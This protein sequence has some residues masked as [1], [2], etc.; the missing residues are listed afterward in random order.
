MISR[1]LIDLGQE[2]VD[3]AAQEVA[4]GGRLVHLQLLA[5]GFYEALRDEMGRATSAEVGALLSAVADH[6]RNTLTVVRAPSLMLVELR[7]A[8]AM[9]SGPSMATVQVR[10]QVA[11][12]QLR[13]IQGG[14]A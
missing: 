4:T 8:V 9:L 2:V 3:K 1:E 7:T 11:R 5:S 10:P 6:C 12:P 13:V 14:L